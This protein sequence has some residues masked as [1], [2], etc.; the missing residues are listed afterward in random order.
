MMGSDPLSS[1][2]AGNP[3]AYAANGYVS[4]SAGSP[5][6]L[7]VYLVAQPTLSDTGT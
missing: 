4:L 7:F 5:H 1:P 3:P 6:L 2:I